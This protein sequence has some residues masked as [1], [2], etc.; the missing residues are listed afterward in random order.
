MEGEEE[1]R[2]KKKEGEEMMYS[3]CFNKERWR[4]EGWKERR[5]RKQLPLGSLHIFLGET[6]CECELWARQLRQA[7]TALSLSTTCLP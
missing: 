7:G 1:R 2:T 4:N 6:R 3:S 5:E